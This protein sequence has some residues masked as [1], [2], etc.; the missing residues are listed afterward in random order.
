VVVKRIAAG[1]ENVPVEENKD[2]R[3]FKLYNKCTYPFSAPPEDLVESWIYIPCT[4][5]MRIAKACIMIK[6]GSKSLVENSLVGRKVAKPFLL[7]NN[8][9]KN[10]I[11]IITEY[12]T[13]KNKEGYIV[14]FN[15]DD[16]EATLTQK[17]V[18]SYILLP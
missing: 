5:F 13:E 6:N 1:L 4:D 10:F 8:T 2:V 11:G 15:S 7:D 16:T 9:F 18:N 17:E 14:R 12:K 3:Y